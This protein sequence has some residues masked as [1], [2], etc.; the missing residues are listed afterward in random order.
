MRLPRAIVGGRAATGC[1]RGQLARRR[2]RRRAR[3]RSS[4]HP[5]PGPCLRGRLPDLG[6]GSPAR[7]D[8]PPPRTSSTRS[9]TRSSRSR[10]RPRAPGRRGGKGVPLPGGRPGVPG[11]GSRRP[12]CR[13]RR[14]PPTPSPSSPRRRP[15]NSP[16]SSCAAETRRS[17][18]CRA[19]GTRTTSSTAS[20]C[21][22]RVGVQ[23]YL[24][25]EQALQDKNSAQALTDQATSEVIREQLKVEA[26]A[27][28]V[29]PGRGGRGG[30]RA[31]GR[32]GAPRRAKQQLVVL[33]EHRAATEA[34]YP[35]AGAAAA[36]QRRRRGCRA[37][38]TSAGH[39][40]DE[41][42]AGRVTECSAGDCIRSTGA[43]DCTRAPTWGGLRRSDL[44]GDRWHR[45]LRGTNGGYGNFVLIDHGGGVQTGYAHIKPGGIYVGRRPAGRD[46]APHRRGGHHRGHPR[47][48][49]STSRCAPAARGRCSDFLAQ[50]GVA[51]G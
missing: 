11:A 25:L 24:V 2:V 14:M 39:G 15:D 31:R 47:D 16:P 5:S 46:R 42:G 38:G 19:P 32:G 36:Q 10:P 45:G 26:E 50:Q 23:A 3:R 27:A 49:T 22:D 13:S 28:L 40:M 29:G 33:Q 1:A 44:R 17:T 8:G 21:R 7:N 6:R 4:R 35:E 12:T 18:C 48:A 41:A 51:L 9:R 30:G 20:R 34:D 37:A 43:G